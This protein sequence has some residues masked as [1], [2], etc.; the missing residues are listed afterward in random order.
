MKLNR[1]LFLGAIG[2]ASVVHPASAAPTNLGAIGEAHRLLF[3]SAFDREIFT[4]AAYRDLIKTNCRI[5]AIENSFKL[6]W[7]RRN[8]PAADF[9]VT[10]RLVK[11]ANDEHIALRGTGLIWNDW[12]PDWLKSLSSNEIGTMLDRHVSE[13]I[14]RYAGRM[15]SWDVVN[16]PFYPPHQRVTGYRKGPWLD[17][18][19]PAYIARA[20]RV[21]AAADPKAKLVLNEAFCEQDDDL[22]RSIRP[23]LLTLVSELK[24]AGIKLDAVG[25]QAH[26]KPH[27][28]F[29]DQAFAAYLERVAALGVDIYITEF[30]VDDSSLPDDIA[31]RDRMVAERCEKF[32]KATLA[33]PRVKALMCWHLSD[34]YSWYKTADWYGEAVIKFGGTARRPVRT[35]LTDTAL[36]PKLAWDAVARAIETR[37]QR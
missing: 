9:T 28:P 32:L 27:L 29:D 11:F 18:L 26:L 3:G 4:D 20:F 37:T 21:A 14:A 33:V 5:G 23:R 8:G 25:F 24:H 35:H 31:I 16:E 6:D 12:P 22:G 10:D 36:K 30:D 19:G 13:T 2:A 1:R 17:A 34:R 7:L 15:H